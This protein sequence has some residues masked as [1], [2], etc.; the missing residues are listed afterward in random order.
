MS[1]VLVLVLFGSTAHGV[2]VHVDHTRVTSEKRGVREWIR[3]DAQATAEINLPLEALLEVIEDY[4]AYPRL[5]PKIRLVSQEDLGDATLVTQ[6]VVVSALGIENVNRF[7]LK[8][9]REWAPG[10]ARVSWTQ[11]V[12]DG[13]IDSLEGSWTLDDVGS[14]GA[15][16]TRL[17]YRSISAV[18]VVVPGQA[19]FVSM[20]LGAEIRSVVEAV[21]KEAVNR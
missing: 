17:V 2:D 19:L 8:M 9:T 21:A 1:L 4:P 3:F 6:K 10:K 12:T 13:S 16:R 14:P 7:T 15:P 5:F 18:P 20:F 11:Y